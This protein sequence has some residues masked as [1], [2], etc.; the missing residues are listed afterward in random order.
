MDYHA[1]NQDNP[2]SAEEA[3][4]DLLRKIV[5]QLDATTRKK[6]EDALEQDREHFSRS[7]TPGHT[8][9]YDHKLAAC[10]AFLRLTNEEGA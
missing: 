1:M 6:I 3:E 10:A 8:L 4:R 2:V 9:W 5:R 7:S